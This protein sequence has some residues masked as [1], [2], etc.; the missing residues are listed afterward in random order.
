MISAGF[1]AN[2]I[3]P[4]PLLPIA[5]SRLDLSYLGGGLG[6]WQLRP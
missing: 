3:R 6:R 4:T 1:T 5:R 2:P